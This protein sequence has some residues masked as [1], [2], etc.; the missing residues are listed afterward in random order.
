MRSFFGWLLLALAFT[1]HRVSAQQPSPSEFL[2]LS[3]W[4]EHQGDDME[5]AAPAFDDSA[6][7]AETQTRA[8]IVDFVAGFR[9]YRTAVDVPPALQNSDLALGMGPLDDVYEVFVEGVSV[10]R[11]G[12]WSPHPDSTFDRNLIFPIP[13]R[14]TS[15]ARL[16]IALRRWTG[17]SSTA[18]FPYYTSGA[19]RF[20]QPVLIG[21]PALIH[22]HMALVAFQGIVHNIPTNVGL[23]GLF[24]AGCIALVLFSAQR[25]HLEYLLLGMYGTVS[26]L[27]PI[28]GALI[29]A[30]D[31]V[32]RRSWIAAIPYAGYIFTLPL[33]LAFLAQLCRPLR[34]VLYVG[35]V[36]MALIGIAGTIAFL[37]G[38]NASH[39]GALYGYDVI[40][41]FDLIAAWGLFRQK[42]PGSAAIATALILSDLSSSWVNHFSHVLGVSDLRFMPLGPVFIDIRSI[43]SLL[44]VFVT[45]SVLYLRFRADQVRQV[46]L[47]R[48]MAAAQR[49]Q[50]QLL[51][52]N[53]LRVPGFSIDAVYLP[54]KEVGGDFYRTVAL[55]DGSL[56]VIV[57]DVSGKGLDAAM[58]VASVLGSLANETERAP[59]ALLTYLNNAVCGRTGGGFITALCLRFYP[60]G[61]VAVAN[62]GHIAPYLNGHEVPMESGFP[63]G[64]QPGI[65]YAETEIP[66]GAATV[67]MLSDGVLEARSAD[68]EL[69]GFERLAKL[70]SQPAAEI[71]L[72]AQRW[73]QE[74]DITV[75]TVTPTTVA[76]Q[77]VVPA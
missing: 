27:I 63:L 52:G 33:T 74:D 9:W 40:A 37:T 51:G 23:L 19:V 20:P 34:K 44:F 61:R 2:A 45:L 28:A 21:T 10:G 60:G 77:V 43:T 42:D 11:F 70:T 7:K 30:N 76:A 58:L 62:A 8:S 41:A 55:S 47:E 3:H 64:I 39:L 53:A 32:L 12:Q 75:L 66:A 25:D 50:Q 38:K 17:G 31:H 68:G 73:G 56:L 59:A 29:A 57:G 6:W 54:A 69:L 1:S 48:D 16:H 22:Q 5:W 71:A 72:A 36:I 13:A 65:P 26:F 15:G 46:V 4:V 18:L 14:L 67:T 35:M 24:V 49:M